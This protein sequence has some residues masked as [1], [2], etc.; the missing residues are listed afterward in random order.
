[1]HWVIAKGLGFLAEGADPPRAFSE[2]DLSHPA[3]ARLALAQI[4]EREKPDAAIVFYAPWWVSQTLWKK[5]I[6]RRIGRKSQWHSYLFLNEG[7]RQSRS[8]SQQHESAYNADLVRFAFSSQSFSSSNGGGS[9]AAPV[10][11]LTPPRLRNLF[12]RFALFPNEYFV[13]HPGMAGSALNWP[14]KSY[15][16]L[17][18]KLIEQKT[19]VITGTKA[20][21]PW[22]TEIQP[23]FASHP[24]VRWLQNSLDIRELLFV[25]ANA[26][27]VIAPSTGVLHMA[28]SLGVK[29]AGIYSPLPAHDQKRWGPRG[30]Q[31]R[32]FVPPAQVPIDEQC[33]SAIQPEDV[34]AWV[35]KE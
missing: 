5:K 19:V 8:Q 6:P 34:S 29:T 7:L 9:T 15:V 28:A 12:E 4:I 22:L 31:V 32:I 27:A 3:A 1:M 2:I 10:L 16:T 23:K 17:I 21:D 13:I 14:Q 24:K 11:K 20:D 33:M 35:L 18:E 30:R 25:L 26:R